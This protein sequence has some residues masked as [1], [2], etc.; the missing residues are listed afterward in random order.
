MLIKILINYEVVIVF[1][2]T[3]SSQIHEDISPLIVIKMIE[4]KVQQE[5]SFLVLRALLLIVLEILRDQLQ[6]EVLEYYNRLYQNLQFLV[7]KKA[8]RIYR[9]INTIMK[10]NLVSLQDVNLPLLVDKFLEEFTRYTIAL[11]I[12]FF[13]RYNQL[14]LAPKYRDIIAFITSLRLL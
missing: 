7:T 8:P 13:S 3:K 2:Q 10:L 12:D 14:V 5:L 6:R 11:L 1:D 9:L 4:H